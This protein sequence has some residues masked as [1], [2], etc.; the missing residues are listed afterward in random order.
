MSDV[1][2]QVAQLVRRL[3]CARDTDIGF[4]GATDIDFSPLRPATEYLLNNVGDPY[5]DPVTGNH[6][7]EQEREVLEYL[8]NLF[9]AP[10]DDRWGYVTSCGTEGNDYG[11]W[12]ARSLYPDGYVYYSEASHYSVGKAV[13]RLALPSRVVRATDTGEIDYS[14]LRSLV[15]PSRPA[16]V[17]ANI[18]TTMTEAVDDLAAIRS[19]LT[20]AGVRRHYLHADAALAGVPLALQAK[21][22]TFGLAAGAH[23][24]TVS[25]H[26]FLGTLEPCGVVITRRSLREHLSRQVAYIGTLDTTIGGSRSGHAALR[27]WYVIRSLGTQG[28][29]RR[30]EQ[31]RALAAYA[32]DAL[33]ELGWEAWR[34]SPHTF[35]VVLKSPPAAM[36]ARWPLAS[37]DGWSHII[38]MP[39]VTRDHIDRFVADL[40]DTI[41]QQVQDRVDA[42]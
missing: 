9:G 8:A 5:I 42:A 35:T 32:L 22:G 38:C 33:T 29:Q 18:G 15:N 17:V 30:A 6:T 37:T 7:K 20:A 3:S 19:T 11:L 34:A 4:P 28:L 2:A 21:P 13:D 41:G 39:G 25:G 24:I 27:L 36:L 23:S 10:L 40:R 12:L 31:S 14:D 1:D 16:I 26:K